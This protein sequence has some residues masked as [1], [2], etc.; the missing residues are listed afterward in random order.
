MQIPFA[1]KLPK[2]QELVASSYNFAEQLLA[3]QRKFTE[4]VLKATAADA[5]GPGRRPGQE[6]R[7]QVTLQ[8]SSPHQHGP[9]VTA[10]PPCCPRESRGWRHP[11]DPGT[12]SADA[13][14][15]AGL[16]SSDLDEAVVLG[17]ALAASGAPDFSC[18]DPV[19]TARS[20]MKVS[21]VSP[22]RWETN[23]R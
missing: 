8:N 10:G 21:S 13:V 3:S 17:D 19:P 7:G 18:P 14:T 16:G 4:D 23:C 15:E 6:D 5:A 2:P 12:R 9:A 1:D 22:E 20:A 11:G